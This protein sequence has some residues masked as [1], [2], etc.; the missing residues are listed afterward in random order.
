[1]TRADH[2]VTPARARAWVQ[3]LRQGGSTPWLDF[4]D[5]AAAPGSSVELPGVAQLELA[6][7]LN[8]AAGHRTGRAHGDLVDRVLLAAAPGRGQQ[9]R[10]LL[11]ARP[12]DPAAVPDSELV[13]IAVGVLSDIVVER[14]PGAAD[15]RRRPRRGILV[16]GPPL[17]VA[18]TLA[19]NGL[20][21]VPPVRPSRVVVLADELDRALAD[22]WAGRIRDGATQTWSGFLATV[23]GHDR[24]PPRANAAAIAQRWAARVGADHVHIVSG[25]GLVQGIRRRPFAAAYPLPVASAHELVREVNAVLRILR[26]ETTHRR[27]VDAVLWPMVADVSGPP[28]RLDLRTHDW[29]TARGER[30]RDAIRSGGYALH[31]DPGHVVPV[32]P[33]ERDPQRDAADRMTVLDVA[34]RTLLGTREEIL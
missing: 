20:P 1:M 32:D 29:L 33:S 10:S 26:D 6:R 14:D 13:R 18:A 24:L 4:P 8:E 7:R 30:M 25:P 9:V 22:V 3:H 17:A 23:R 28:P 16:L 15:A 12:V 2:P 27:L 19:T 11:D 34:L 31:G 21:P 5:D